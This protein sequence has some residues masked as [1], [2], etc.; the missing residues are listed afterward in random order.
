MRISAC[1]RSDIGLRRSNNEDAWLADTES[2][3][4]LVADG[5]GGA[6]A[7]EVASGLFARTAA[8]VVVSGPHRSEALAVACLRRVFTEARQAILRHVAH[9]PAHA[10]MGCTAELLLLH[11]SGFV[12][13]HVGDSRTYLLRG[14]RLRL[15]TRD[16]T[17]VQQEMDQGIVSP[18]EA[19]HRLMRNV[20]L[21]AVT[22][23]GPANEDI[24]RG[25]CMA[26]DLFL[27]C[28]DGFS[29]MVDD[30]RIL[31]LLVRPAP[32][33]EKAARC[34]DAARRAGGGDNITVVLVAVE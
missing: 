29:D 6:A 13:G 28:S 20:L 25:Q 32:L 11:R 9:H 31:E 8:R 34:I 18:A 17:L 4:F 19:R 5:M 2:G 10:A 33:A 24:I 12:L 26:A 7:G 30:A 22:A 21:R 15:L 14:G 27:L 1:G 3:L 23:N 16:H